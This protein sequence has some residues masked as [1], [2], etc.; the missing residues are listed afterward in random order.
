ME[1]AAQYI[2][3]PGRHLVNTRFQARYLRGLLTCEHEIVAGIKGGFAL[4][5]G[6]Q[7]IFAVT[8]ANQQNSRYNA[9]PFPIR[10]VGL[11]RFASALAREVPAFPLR[12]RILGIP[13]YGHTEN[14][15]EVTLK[16]IEYQT[17]GEL[18]LVPA[19]TLVLC[20]TPE[21]IAGYER[22][23]FSIAPAE[24]GRTPRPA[25]PGS[26]TAGVGESDDWKSMPH[27]D[28]L[29]PSHVALFE[30][31][32][33]VPRQIRRIY[34]D[35]ITNQEGSLT[36]NRNY[37]TYARGMNEITAMKFR[38][39]AAAIKPGRIADEGCADGAL[40]AEV[41]RVFRDSDLFGVDLSSEFASRFAERQ[42]SGE[43]GNL[44][45]HFFHR[46]LLEPIFEAGSI[47]TTI[48]NS[49]L[50]E[51]WSYAGGEPTVRKYLREKF[52]Q[53]R[54]GGRL[55]IRDVVGPEN[56]GAQVL[57][58]CSRDDG[59][60]LPAG[61]LDLHTAREPDWIQSLSTRAKFLLFARDFRP[62]SRGN[63]T[64][65]F[66]PREDGFL[67]S[68]AAAAEFLSKKDYADNW[69]SEVQ[70]EF[71]FWN[72][73]QWKSAL[74]EAGFSIIENQ[75]AEKA[76]SRIYTNPWIVEHRFQNHIQL[77]TLGAGGEKSPIPWPPTNMVLIGEKALS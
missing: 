35:P 45:V 54:P 47:D 2:L 62:A 28:E 74:R 29:A 33:E 6:A 15:V 24:L 21:V 69:K 30:D 14:F 57:L 22:L 42:R 65:Q 58:E 23:G 11:D 76:N 12:R 53:L 63:S 51:L 44:Y 60:D 10:M 4:R 32:P 41:S 73:A 39:I 31:F 61:E 68:L 3:F 7:V 34:R 19:N 49:T 36:E 66:E 40:L 37:N 43:F 20:S 75:P 56:G 71:C 48:C 77:F 50:H 27:I 16:E 64:I 67:T 8:S 52:R 9:I 70:E 25:T 17:E 1:Q 46:N 38:D 18:R 13:H 5:P 55:V 72:F 59:A 26:L